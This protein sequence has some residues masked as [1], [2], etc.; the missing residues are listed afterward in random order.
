VTRSGDRSFGEVIPAALDGERLDRVVSLLAGCSRAGAAALV[1]GGAVEVDGLV[2][3][4]GKRR[5][6]EGQ[7]VSLD[8]TALPVE[9]V[10][11]PDPDVPVVV[12]H[13]DDDVIVVDKP[14]RLVVHPGAGQRRGTLVNGLLARYPELA[15]VGDAMRPGIVHRLDRDTSGL[16][17]VARTQAAYEALVAA[18]SARL[19]TRRYVALVWG[20][21]ETRQGVIEAPI[22]RSPRQPTR[23]AVVG[24]GREARTRYEVRATFD[25]PATCALVACELETGRTHQI[26]VH[27]AAIGHPVVGDREY[28]G[29]R[30]ALEA[31]RTFLHAEHLAFDHPVSG[32]PM[33]FDSPVPD[34][35]T[36]VLAAFGSERP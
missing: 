10:P 4:L 16:L 29:V 21:P 9:A 17:V 24:T 27:L 18:L 7:R 5:V 32:R 15:G 8:I 31:P 19:V 3:T 23:M 11:E 36:R 12:V 28:R 6:A 25:E 34:D 1:A 2:V 33:A 20:I 14:P 30:S 13:E 22:G 26:R 35:L